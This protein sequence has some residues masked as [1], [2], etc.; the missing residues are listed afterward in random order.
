MKSLNSILKVALLQ[1]KCVANK[2]SNLQSIEQAVLEAAQNKAK[3]CF[4]GEIVNSPYDKKYMREYAEDLGNSET[5]QL[6][7]KLSKQFGIYT[8][9]TIPEKGKTGKLYNT[10][11]V[12]NMPLMQDLTEWRVAYEDEQGSFVRH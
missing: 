12:V 10:G 5:L 9:S 8:I 11:I 7:Q 1:T 6:L 2:Q 4:L 3:I